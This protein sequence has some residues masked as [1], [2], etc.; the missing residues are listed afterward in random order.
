MTTLIYEERLVDAGEIRLNLV[1]TGAGEPLV[2]LHGAG[3]GATGIS[4]FRGNLPAFAGHR[5]LVFD[6]P[7]F[8]KSDK[9]V[10]S[11]ERG[12]MF[13]PYAAE[14]IAHALDGIGIERCSLIG[15]SMGGATAIRFA[16]EHPEK[17]NRLVL[18]AAAGTV[19]ADWDGGFPEGLLKIVEWMHSGPSEQLV[20]EF[21][22][23][24]VHD[25]DT[26]TEEMIEERLKGAAD[27]EIV[28][29]NRET[30]AL[31]GD[32][33]PDLARVTAPTLLLWGREDRFIP[34][35]WGLNALRHIPD[36][37][38]RILPRCGHW[39]QFEKREQFNQ[40]VKDFLEETHE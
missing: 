26:I 21:A 2:W 38:M 22:A 10:L 7:R 13:A 6:L 40:I 19:P 20:R 30:N 12:E 15:N 5:N 18:M 33:N 11:L 29:T 4:N 1:E 23:L 24:Q 32:L 14:A 16:A 34:L 17:V 37:E 25:P 3:P 8:G 27:P 36:A 9:P 28:S 39:V 31:P 35:E